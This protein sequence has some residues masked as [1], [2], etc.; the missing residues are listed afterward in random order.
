MIYPTGTKGGQQHLSDRSVEQYCPRIDRRSVRHCIRGIDYQVSEWGDPS[1]RLLVLLHGWG[2]AGST[3]QFVVDELE[4]EWFVIAPDWRGFGE[5]HGRAD[6]YWFPDY[7]ADLD[8][9]LSIYSPDDAVNI[10]GHS[11]GGNN[12]GLY[13]GVFTD[14]VA[15]LINVEGFGLADRDPADAPA[16]YRRW[17]EMGRQGTAYRSYD[18]YAELAKRIQRQSP[19]MTSER[20]Q[21]VATL[22]AD[23]CPD[24]LVRIK[25]DPA[26]KLPNAILYRRRETEAC[27]SQVTASVLMVVGAESRFRPGAVSGSAA[28]AYLPPLAAAEIA[29]VKR[30]GHMVHFDGERFLGPY[31]NQSAEA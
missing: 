3:F 7:V 5:T 2:D 18:S 23:R 30:S 19:H 6:S 1:S 8:A 16:N 28:D 24:D 27:W 31:E 26:H 14:R 12:A 11:M 9:L 22:W 10:L 25:A 20:A 15:A 13:A 21:F 29:T 4:D 17:I